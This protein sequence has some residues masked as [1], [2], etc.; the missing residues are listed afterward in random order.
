MAKANVRFAHDL[1]V[2]PPLGADVETETG[3]VEVLVLNQA[4]PSDPLDTL[5]V[6]ALKIGKRCGARCSVI[7]TGDARADLRTAV[8]GMI[9]MAINNAAEIR[10]AIAMEKA[11]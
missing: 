4:D 10:D 11:V 7:R 1:T 2:P 8:A 5:L 6:V 9:L 3:P